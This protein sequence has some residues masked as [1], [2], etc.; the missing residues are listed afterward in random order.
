MAT[1]PPSAA[2]ASDSAPPPPWLA[3]AVEALRSADALFFHAGAGM[4][5]DSGLPDFRGPQGFWR[6]YP[7]MKKLVRAR[8]V[9]LPAP[10]PGLVR[11]QQH[12]APRARPARV[13]RCAFA[14][15]HM[16]HTCATHRLCI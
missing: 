7:P 15:T 4:G 12:N 9:V 14:L 5:V 2:A 1:A 3:A 13:F 16:V 6:A 10:A 11:A 8:G